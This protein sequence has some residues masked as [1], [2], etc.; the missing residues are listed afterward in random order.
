[1]VLWVCSSS[2][3]R[4][5]SATCDCGTYWAFYYLFGFLICRLTEVSIRRHATVRMQNLC[6]R[7][8]RRNN[9][10]LFISH[11]KSLIHKRKY[12]LLLQ[13]TVWT[14]LLSNKSK[15]CLSVAATVVLLCQYENYIWSATWQNQQNDCAQSKDSDQPPVWSESSLSAWRNIGPLATHWVHSEDSDQTGWMPRLIWIFA[16]HTIILLVLSCRGSYIL[17]I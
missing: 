1:M 3:C 8:L 17:W 10:S 11:T 12:W 2:G 15:I 5:L 7:V 9:V 13:M 6:F 4:R 14:R 16:G